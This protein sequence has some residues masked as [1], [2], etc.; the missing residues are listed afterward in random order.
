VSGKYVGA[1]VRRRE[2]PRLLTGAA[3][4]VDDVKVVGCLHAAVL[5][6]SH[7]H[8]RIRAIAADRA[9]RHPGV[10]GSWSFQDLASGLRPLPTSGLPPAALQAR[11]GF[12]MKSAPQ[13]P[14]AATK[15]RYVGE[16][17]AVV[18]A[19]DRYL[20]EDALDLIA[21]ESDPLPAVVDAEAA[22]GGGAPLVH[23]EWGDNL[24][25]D[26]HHAIGDVERAFAA[27][28][29]VVRE[30][31]SMRRSA[32]M[33]L[34]P[35]GILA[36]PD[37]RGGLAVWAS[38]Q[39]PHLLQRALMEALGLPA[40]KVRVRAPDVGG[41]FGTKCT[42]YPE[43]VLVPLLAM[44]L[45]RPVKWIETRREHFQ[46][47]THSREQLHE[48]ALA[49]ARDGEILALRDRFVLDQGAY[50]PWGIVQP[51][52]TVT[53]LLGPYRIRHL[54]V[55]ARVVVTNKTPNA[56]Y[57]GAGRPEAVFVMDRMIDRLA[58]ELGRDPVEIRRRNLV[59]A[60]ELPY[61]LGLLYRDGQP[62]VY[63]SGDFPAA[64]EAAL[65]AAGYAEFRD[66]QEALWRRGVYRGIGISAYVEGTGIGPFE[67]ATVR[68]DRSG[69]VVVATGACSQGQGHET[70]FA[71]V[72]ADGLGVP[73]ED[74]TVVGGD[75]DAI[76][77]GV[78]TFASRSAVLAGNAIAEAGRKVK[79]KLVRAAA[80]LLEA[81]LEDL[82]VADGHVL[83]RG[84]PDRALPFAR[85]IEATLPTFAGPGVADP[86]FE[87]TSYATVPTVTYASAVHVAVVDVDPETGVARVQRYVVS[88]DCGRVINPMIVE[89]QIQGGVAQGIG[90]GLYED[91]VYDASGQLL[92]ATLMD[93]HLPVAT[94]IPAVEI[95]H[96][97]CPSPRNPLGLKGLGEGGAISGPAAISNAIEDAL[98]PFGVRVV[99]TPLS[100]AAL[101]ALMSARA[102]LR[103]ISADE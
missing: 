9:R 25:L 103:R 18:V 48:V 73:L 76:P 100:P 33:P 12:R 32:G 83:V 53:H 64:L 95:V 31:L 63:D 22:L 74:V 65:D 52:N 3:R 78:G 7:A 34:E 59:R 54:A 43:D 98:A 44:A 58:R 35:R 30:R 17:V 6:S 38:T 62:L 89:G 69:K 11:V 97:E 79:E 36:I 13:Y 96:L 20:A 21:V 55:E 67:G 40:H 23:D 82:E 86:D 90:G 72:A 80:A 8:A 29:V 91:L 77:F 26:F 81:R 61:D 94:E 46:S 1:I 49:A 84:V 5:R 88:H 99:E 19:T 57:R 60:D 75:T 50:N 16:P 37:A 56:P 10:A 70:T 51:Y 39:V 27:A 68:L 47:A 66:A 14:L 4:F 42:I 102:P 41:G 28:P 71:Q 2:D 87:A 93:Y 24:A 92:T 85:I 101:R 15:M 45:G